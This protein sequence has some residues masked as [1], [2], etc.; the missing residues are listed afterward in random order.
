M[1]F[2]AKGY[3]H[4][5]FDDNEEEAQ[6]EISRNTGIPLADIQVRSVRNQLFHYYKSFPCCEALTGLVVAVEITYELK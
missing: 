4:R 6:K 1:R 3:S 2:V 5:N